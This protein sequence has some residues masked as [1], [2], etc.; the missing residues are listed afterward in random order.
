MKA[1]F[2][3]L[4]ATSVWGNGHATNYRALISAMLHRGH[5]VLFLERNRPWYASARDF[6]AAW[7]ELYDEIDDLDL[8]SDQVADADLVVIGSFVPDGCDVAERMLDRA[9]G[10]TAFWD[11]DTPVTAAKIAQGDYEYL[12]PELIRRFDLYLSFTG[13]PLLQQIG[14]RRPR[15]FYCMA[16]PRVYRPL[17]IP[18][19]WQL[20]Y[21]GTYSDDRPGSNSR[22][23]EPATRSPSICPRTW[24]DSTPSH[25]RV[26]LRS[27]GRSDSAST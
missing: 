20:G 8:W 4:S 26:T 17:N 21:L 11:I 27:T 6:D 10:V 24:I 1:V 13:G 18:T 2:L 5:E 19:R 16:D 12:S 25:P 22:L 14:A 15:A 9:R 23:P 3:G 7:I